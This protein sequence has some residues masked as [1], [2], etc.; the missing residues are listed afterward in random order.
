[1]KILTPPQRSFWHFNRILFFLTDFTL[2]FGCVLVAFRLSPS[3]HHPWSIHAS[4][5]PVYLQAT[6]LPLCLALGLQLSNIQKLQAK[7]K[8]T[9]TLVRIIFGSGLGAV[10]FIVFHAFVH[11]QLAGRYIIIISWLLGVMVTFLARALLWR[12]NH[13]RPRV[14]LFWGNENI[15]QECMKSLHKSNTPIYLIGRFENGGIYPISRLRLF[16]SDPSATKIPQEFQTPPP[17]LSPFDPPQP[18]SIN[19]LAQLCIK[20][21]VESLILANPHRLTDLEKRELTLLISKGLK[22]HTLNYFY[23]REFERIHVSSVSD[24]WLWDH[25]A[26]TKSPYYLGAK[27]LIDISLSLIALVILTPIIPFIVLLIWSQDRGP[28]LY[29]QKRVGQYDIPFWI[30]KFRTMRVNAESNGAQWAQRNDQRVTVL[31]KWLRKSRLDEVPQFYNILRG[32]MSFIGPRPEREELLKQIESEIPYFRFR[33]LIKPG[34]SGWA[35]INYGYGSNID[36]AKMK[37]SYDLYY[38]KHANL[39]LDLLIV[40]RTFGAMM[41]GAR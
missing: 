20:L 24:S 38:L 13:L 33:N 25:E 10:F 1:M 22:V 5:S 23:E 6:F 31:G 17:E 16:F 2:F 21:Q 26:T 34:L 14:I 15:A 9:D 32:D 12:L 27:R 41:R 35:Q 30:Y 18:T 40:L 37:L 4:E 7:F 8:R 36:D 3:N 11:Y 28:I 19:D 39:A 29:R